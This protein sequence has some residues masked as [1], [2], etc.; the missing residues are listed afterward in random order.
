[1]RYKPKIGEELALSAAVI[2]AKTRQARECTRSTIA[3][4][5]MVAAL[6]ALVSGARFGLYH[7]DFSVLQTVWAIIA[8][9][10]GYVIAHYFRDSNTDGKEDNNSRTA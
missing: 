10:V 3:L 9:P 4:L 2:A 5:I 1:M 8:V 7:G 6:L